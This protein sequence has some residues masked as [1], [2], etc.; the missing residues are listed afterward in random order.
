MG[1]WRRFAA[2]SVPVAEQT[3]P[4]AA[5]RALVAAQTASVAAQTAPVIELE[6][7][8]A[9]AAASLGERRGA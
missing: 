2:L 6:A 8:S 3:A 7:L 1:G 5:T 4:S 9:L